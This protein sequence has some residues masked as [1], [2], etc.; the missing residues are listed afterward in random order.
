MNSYPL[1][2]ACPSCLSH[3]DLAEQIRDHFMNHLAD[4]DLAKHVNVTM[5]DIPRLR[6]GLVGAQVRWMDR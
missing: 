5:T 4:I 6:E 3:N 1:P 2:S